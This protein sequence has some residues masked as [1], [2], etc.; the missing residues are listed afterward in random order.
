[1]AAQHP[2]DD[3]A[4]GHFESGGPVSCVDRVDRRVDATHGDG[5]RDGLAGD[6]PLAGASDGQGARAVEKV[7]G[8][9]RAEDRRRERLK[10]RALAIGEAGLGHGDPY[11]VGVDL[12]PRR[13]HRAGHVGVR[14]A[15][16]GLAEEGSDAAVRLAH[17]RDAVDRLVGVTGEV[18]V[19][20]GDDLALGRGQ[21][22]HLEDDLDLA[23]GVGDLD[24]DE[25]VR[26]TAGRIPARVVVVLDVGAGRR[27]DEEGEG[28]GRHDGSAEAR[29]P[30]RLAA[31]SRDPAAPPMSLPSGLA[32]LDAQAA[33]AAFGA[34][35]GRARATVRLPSPAFHHRGPS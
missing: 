25:V 18:H 7:G 28:K 8:V 21:R 1:M 16:A 12:A 22:R 23:G 3:G 14:V 24:V 9:L 32:D 34:G 5:L 13:G 10:P 11:E 33:F 30:R 20:L 2:V 26:R 35:P 15:R 19:H 29:H 4:G 6:C 27:G 31:G 17:R